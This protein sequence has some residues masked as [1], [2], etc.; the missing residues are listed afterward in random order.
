MSEQEGKGGLARLEAA[1]GLVLSAAQKHRVRVYIDMLRQWNTHVNLTGIERVEEHL[2]LN[3]FEAFWAA[4]EFLEEGSSLA[5]VGTGAG[6]PGLAM[7]VYRPC[8]QVTLIEPNYKKVV[9]LKEA[10]RA[11]ELAVPVFAGRGEEFSRWEEVDVAAFRALRPPP[12]LLTRLARGGVR[13]LLFEGR[14]G[15]RDGRIR[16]LREARVPLSKQ[17]WVRLARI[18]P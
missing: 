6:F 11:L 14:E 17:R 7:K 16:V 15:L 9:F 8:L 2:R 10:A 3:F 5:D 1:F 4:R 13:L 12:G 18:A